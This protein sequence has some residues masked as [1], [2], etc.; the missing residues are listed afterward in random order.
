MANLTD[1]QVVTALER[2]A[3]T[4]LKLTEAA[5]PADVNADA[6]TLVYDVSVLRAQIAQ[7]EE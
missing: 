7:P 6:R 4:I 5:R 2:V 3:A 1:D